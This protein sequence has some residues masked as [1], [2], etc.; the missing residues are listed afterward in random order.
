[1]AMRARD[2]WTWQGTL[3]RGDYARWGVLLFAIKYNLDRFIALTA[4]G[5]PWYPWTYLL[6]TGHT[7]PPAGP[8]PTG[9]LFGILVTSLPF[10]GWGVIMTLRRLRDAGWSRTLVVLFFVPFVNLLF[11]SFLCLQPAREPPPLGRE[12]PAWWRRIL[13]T[14]SPAFSA[15]LGIM[16][17]VI[18]GFGLTVI[19]TLFFKN[20]GVGLFVGTPFMMGFF[21]ALFHSLARPRTWSE[22]A[23]V[24]MVSVLIVGV[25]LVLFAVE[26]LVCL[27]M[28]APIGVLLALLGATVGWIV[29]LERWSHRLDQVR[30]YAAAWMLAPLLL[31]LEASQPRFRS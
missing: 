27:L 25:I 2:L 9:L 10:I 31:A 24:A 20:Y 18:L 22:C 8:Q 4:F 15:G 19:A 5:T 1:M 16:A 13:A 12:P 3:G 6:G 30:L 11:F 28:A 29:Q 26:G 23:V 7:N 14:D 17:S 21:S